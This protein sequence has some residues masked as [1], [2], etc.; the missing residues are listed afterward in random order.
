MQEMTMQEVDVV[1]GAVTDAQA[2][3]YALIAVG[4]V[5]AGPVVGAAFLAGFAMTVGIGLLTASAW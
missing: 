1:S 4:L 2:A 5:A 3:G